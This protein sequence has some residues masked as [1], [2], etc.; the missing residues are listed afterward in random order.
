MARSP[1]KNS[2]RVTH[3]MPFFL[4]KKQELEIMN[5]IDSTDIDAQNFFLDR[6]ETHIHIKENTDEVNKSAPYSFHFTNENLEFHQ[7]MYRNLTVEDEEC[8]HIGNEGSDD[9]D[10]YLTASEQKHDSVPTTTVIEAKSPHLSN[11]DLLKISPYESGIRYYIDL[12][13]HASKKGCFVY[14]NYLQDDD[15]HTDNLLFAKLISLNS[16]HFDYDNCN[17]TIKNMYMRDKR[18]GLSK[19]G[20]GRVALYK[21]LG[22]HLSTQMY[23]QIL[24]NRCHLF[25]GILHSYTLECSYAV[26]KTCQ[27]LPAAENEHF[28]GRVSP[29][30]PYSLPQKLT[31]EHYKDVG[32][33]CALAALDILPGQNPF[34]RVTQSTFRTLQALKDYLK[35]QVRIQRNRTNRTSVAPPPTN[36]NV[37]NS[38][39]K[40]QL[41]YASKIHNYNNKPTNLNNN[42]QSTTPTSPSLPSQTMCAPSSTS[43]TKAANRFISSNLKFRSNSRRNINNKQN[44]PAQIESNPSDTFPQSLSRLEISSRTPSSLKLVHSSSARLREQQLNQ[45]KFNQTIPIS[46]IDPVLISRHNLLRF[47][48]NKLPMPKKIQREEFNLSSL[49]VSPLDIHYCHTRMGQSAPQNLIKR[50]LAHTLKQQPQEH[51]QL[52]LPTDHLVPMKATFLTYKQDNIQNSPRALFE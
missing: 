23:D 45:M 37:T 43:M 32:K 46:I 39:G 10:E 26:G 25:L 34:T 11:V 9:E 15:M 4:Q 5:Q 27:S 20:S 50:T 40:Q 30:Y 22:M 17:F 44:Y 8:Y 21:H 33:A 19:E 49:P 42:T 13:G 16:P 52:P 38:K 28:G 48:A 1:R 24:L 3:D 36:S 41:H 31:Q 18:E 35:H 29:A 6:R 14:G 7:D 51:H 2:D 12:H 47:A